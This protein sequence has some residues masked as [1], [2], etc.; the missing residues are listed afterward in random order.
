MRTEIGNWAQIVQGVYPA[1]ITW[2]QF[3]ANLSRLR[4]LSGQHFAAKADGAS[5][6]EREGKAL[7]QGLT[8]CGR[9]GHRLHV[10]YN[11]DGWYFCSAHNETGTPGCPAIPCTFTD[12]AVK[13]AFFEA[14]EPSQLD[15]LEA[16]LAER[17]E[18]YAKLD[19]HWQERLERLRYEAEVAD[20]RFHGVDPRNRLVAAEL[21]RRWEEKLLEVGRAEQEFESFLR[22]PASLKPEL[23][24]AFRRISETLPALWDG[25]RISHQQKKAI[26]RSLISNVVLK[27]AVQ[28]AVEIKIVWVSGH[29]SEKTVAVPVRSVRDLSN[30]EEMA[31]RVHC[32]WREGSTNR[33][34]ANIL[35]AEGFR[36][37]R[38]AP[39]IIET[40]L[41]IRRS[42]GWSS[43]HKRR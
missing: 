36:S 3:K 31:A 22:R 15:A 42:H 13:E 4:Q 7:L 11:N 19:R 34:I 29:C 40:V 38:T 6:V 23:C 26:V 20:Q 9:C 30:Y 41:Q 25:T 2:K 1:F 33:Q 10:N 35:S 14:L 21:E 16:L 12:R 28:E 5:G 24:D 43:Q 32:L 37:A 27:R 18:E 17:E 8:I 39:V